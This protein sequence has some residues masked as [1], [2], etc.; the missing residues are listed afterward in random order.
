MVNGLQD[1]KVVVDVRYAI[2]NYPED[3]TIAAH[4]VALGLI[5]RGNTQEEAVMRCKRLFNKF[6]RA[7]RSVG[8]LEERLN[9]TKVQWWWLDEYPND[10]PDPEDTSQLIQPRRVP[11]IGERQETHRQLHSAL[12]DA[13]HREVT[14]PPLAVAA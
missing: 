4:F 3:N 14:L 1:R 13:Q 9:Q 6:V 2:E 12:Q 7:Y 8:Q 10:R 11:T 5:A